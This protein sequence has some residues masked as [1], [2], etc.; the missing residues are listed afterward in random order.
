MGNDSVKG[1][2]KVLGVDL[3]KNR[4]QLHGVDQDGQVVL[5]KKLSR[6]RLLEAM[7]T[8]ARCV[9]GMEACGGAH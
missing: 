2:I 3:S 4:F 1:E 9:V 5:C 8:L 6:K 7:V